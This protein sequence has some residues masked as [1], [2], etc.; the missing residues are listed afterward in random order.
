MARCYLCD[1]RFEVGE[2][3]FTNGARALCTECADGISIED[4]QLLTGTKSCRALLPELGFEKS[5]L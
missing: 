2:V 3:F 1:G 4:L 5:F